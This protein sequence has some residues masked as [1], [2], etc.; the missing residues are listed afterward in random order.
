MPQEENSSRRVVIVGIPGV[1]KSSVVEKVVEIL[2]S[3][4][5]QFEVVNFGSVMM[6]KATELHGVK[7]RDEIRKLPVDA[8]RKLQIHAA[9]EISKLE[10]RNVI[11]DTHL[12]IAT[13]EGFWPGMPMDVLQALRP[14][15]LVMVV[16]TPEEIISR[17]QN[18][19]SRARDTATR[20]RLQLELSVADAFLYSSC[21]VVGCPALV[22]NNQTGGVNDA[23]EKIINA[24]LPG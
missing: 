11:V 5:A 1:G 3:R 21:L 7:S 19:S 22:V 18:D 17:R 23:A 10:K 24:A 8:Q 9:N 6:K 14:T 16:A 20:E 13:S 12:F 15:N 4:G 2:K